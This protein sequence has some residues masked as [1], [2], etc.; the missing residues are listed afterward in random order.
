MAYR[1]CTCA[2][3]IRRRGAVV[4]EKYGIATASSGLPRKTGRQK[5]KKRKIEENRRICA[6]VMALIECRRHF[7]DTLPVPILAKHS[8]RDYLARAGLGWCLV[9]IRGMQ[10]HNFLFTKPAHP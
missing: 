1:F 2:E 4:R 3:M 7:D 6:L 9:G 8:A 5:K 10:H